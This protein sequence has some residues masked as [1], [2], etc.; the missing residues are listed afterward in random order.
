M[1]NTFKD[2]SKHKFSA[3]DKV[4]WHFK[5]TGYLHCGCFNLFCNVWLCVC[6]GFNVCVCVC[7]CVGL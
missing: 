1:L 7:V 5:I 3:R 2:K 4:I 6:V